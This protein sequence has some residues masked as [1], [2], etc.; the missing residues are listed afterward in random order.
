MMVVKMAVA[1][2]TWQVAVAKVWQGG[3]GSGSGS[4]WVAVRQ[5]MGGS[6]GVWQ[7]KKWRELDEY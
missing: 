2:A 3:S 7:V 1:V 4:G 5:W 6:G